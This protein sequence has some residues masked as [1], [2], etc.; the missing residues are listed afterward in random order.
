[1]LHFTKQEGNYDMVIQFATDLELDGWL[2]LV[3]S[4]KD[5]FPG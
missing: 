4:V 1:M 2:A 3:N 5:A